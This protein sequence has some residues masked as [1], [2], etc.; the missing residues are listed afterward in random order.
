MRKIV[1]GLLCAALTVLGISFAPMASADTYH[2]YA[3]NCYANGY[4]H[5]ADHS[6]VIHTDGTYD[7]YHSDYYNQ[8]SASLLDRQVE[9]GNVVSAYSQGAFVGSESI[10]YPQAQFANQHYLDNFYFKTVFTQSDGH[11][12]TVWID[13]LGN[14]SHLNG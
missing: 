6:F 11:S 5:R 14:V 2:F 9:D 13:A 1:L 12:C 3:E 7:A 4:Q 10:D 8:A